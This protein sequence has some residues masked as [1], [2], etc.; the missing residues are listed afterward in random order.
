MYVQAKPI[1]YLTKTDEIAADYCLQ[2]KTKQNKSYFNSQDSW[3][4]V[5]FI[6]LY[7]YFLFCSGSTLGS[8]EVSL[9]VSSGDYTL[10]ISGD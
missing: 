1:C 8:T 4:T 3:R 6:Y 2:N 5:L 7:A 9:L 10:C